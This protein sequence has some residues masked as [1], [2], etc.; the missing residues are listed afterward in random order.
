MAINLSTEDHEEIEAL[1]YRNTTVL[2]NPG[3]AISITS[4]SNV[5]GVQISQASG[6]NINMLNNVTSNFA[7]NDNQSLVI[8]DQF[9][10]VGGNDSSYVGGDSTRRVEG[11][12]ITLIGIPDEPYMDSENMPDGSHQEPD[13]S[14]TGDVDDIPIEPSPE[15]GCQESGSNPG[16][17]NKIGNTK[18]R[19]K[20]SLAEKIFD[21]NISQ[22][23]SL[24]GGFTFPNGQPLQYDGIRASNPNLDKMMT[25]VENFFDGGMIVP[26]ITSALNEVTSFANICV[27]MPKI[28][29]A[30]Q[31]TPDNLNLV[32]GKDG[33]ND[34]Q[35][36]PGGTDPG[37]GIPTP[38]DISE[39]PSTAGGTYAT[40]PSASNENLTS[41]T[42]DRVEAEKGVKA[43]KDWLINTSGNAVSIIGSGVNTNPMMAVDQKGGVQDIGMALTPQ[44]TTGITG[45]IPS[46]TLTPQVGNK[47]NG[48]QIISAANSYNLM[49]GS[50]GI[51]LGTTGA[52][53]LKS[54][55]YTQTSL[56]TDIIA[57]EGLKLHSSKYAIL[58]GDTGVLI[59]PGKDQIYL[60]GPTAIGGN[61]L[62]EGGLHCEGE[63]FAHHITAPMEVQQT[64]DVRVFAKH[65]TQNTH[66]SINGGAS[67]SGDST[68][69]LLIGAAYI[70]AETFRTVMTTSTGTC[71]DGTIVM[72]PHDHAWPLEDVWLGVYAN[73][74]E[75]LTR[76]YDHG[77]QFANA[78]LRLT[79]SNNDV[80][81]IAHTGGINKL[82]GTVVVA[83]PVT[84][85]KKIME[86]SLCGIS[87]PDPFC[88]LDVLGVPPSVPGIDGLPNVPTL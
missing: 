81:S 76:V 58:K 2:T 88:I 71:S 45:G 6:S 27:P 67:G 47:H 46:Y 3:G 78:P 40:N 74:E 39:S 59:D 34:P 36:M 75:N 84:H 50:G 86:P 52:M 72:N 79:P 35:Y 60:K 24:R 43:T 33:R 22:F 63:I 44:G 12:E 23:A 15:N 4:T 37:N 70:K 31:I 55:V 1:T 17:P 7:A 21:E 13:G 64:N 82:D 54:S 77:H 66:P 20:L 18:N 57:S 14:L 8:N 62:I 80:R 65:N 19:K 87:I 29:S 11:D 85:G 83:S 49:A 26:T 38:L 28:A 61:V 30:K 56:F 48:N 69:N 68:D 10:T 51:D 5:E 25:S 42:K 73:N 16:S 32:M 41:L 9:S 53:H